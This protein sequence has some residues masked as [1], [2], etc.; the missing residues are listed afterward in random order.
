LPVKPPSNEGHE[1]EEEPLTWVYIE[2]DVMSMTLKAYILGKKNHVTSP[3]IAQAV[4]R[5]PV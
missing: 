2:P 4:A 1:F 5:P 3:A